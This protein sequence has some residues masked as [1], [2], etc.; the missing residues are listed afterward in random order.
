MLEKI[1]VVLFVLGFYGFLYWFANSLIKD[2]KKKDTAKPNNKPVEQKS[3]SSNT[4]M[5]EAIGFSSHNHFRNFETLESDSIHV[6]AIALL[7]EELGISETDLLGYLGLPENTVNDCI[8]SNDSLLNFHGANLV[9]G[10]ADTLD[11]ANRVL[12]TKEIAVEWMKEPAKF[13]DDRKPIEVVKNITGIKAVN[14]LL[15]QIEHS[16]YS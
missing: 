10:L 7:A 12:G 13:L 11:T 15:M 3:I 14:Q 4:S 9:Y 16:V 5:L 6:N 1:I 8:E 2:P